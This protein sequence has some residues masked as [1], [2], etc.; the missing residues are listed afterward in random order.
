MKLAWMTALLPCVFACQRQFLP[1]PPFADP[2]SD[3]RFSDNP[4]T[5]YR[6]VPITPNTAHLASVGRPRFSITPE[7]PLGLVLD[8]A[9]GTIA[10]TPAIELSA[11][12]FMVSVDDGIGATQDELVIEV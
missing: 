10:G 12:R 1:L 6:L 7:L 5:Y 3:L 8:P 11:T 9:T 4:A 2:P